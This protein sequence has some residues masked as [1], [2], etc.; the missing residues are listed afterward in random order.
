MQ[1]QEEIR[2]SKSTDGGSTSINTSPRKKSASLSQPPPYNMDKESDISQEQFHSKKRHLIIITEAGKPVYSR[3]GDEAELSPIVA[4]IS[5][6]VNKLRNLKGNGEQV[7]VRRIETNVTK[8]LIFHKHNLFL[9][10]ITRV[11]SD[12][13]F[14]IQQLADSIFHQ[15]A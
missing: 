6:I 5:V 9:I 3:Y 8:T 11:I 12:N 13:D 15:V 1:S 7:S 10:Y 4:T 2:D 14:L